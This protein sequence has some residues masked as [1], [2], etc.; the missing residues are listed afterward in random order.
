MRFTEAR[1][2]IG[3]L[4]YSQTKIL[5]RGLE[6]F[7]YCPANCFNATGAWHGMQLAA[8]LVVIN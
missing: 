2:F 1:T 8:G 3:V 6:S 7:F 4:S 5:S